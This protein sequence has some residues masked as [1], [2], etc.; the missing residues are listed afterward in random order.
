MREGVLV[1]VDAALE[2]TS[3]VD[4]PKYT[5]VVEGSLV[6]QLIVTELEARL[7]RDIPEMI[8]AMT[9]GV[10]VGVVPIPI[11]LAIPGGSVWHV[12]T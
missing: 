9:S 7:E 2:R 3:G 12:G 1:P 8:G 6:V 4:V 11:F 10:V 5:L